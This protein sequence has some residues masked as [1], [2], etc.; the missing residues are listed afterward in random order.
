MFILHHDEETGIVAEQLD[1]PTEGAL[2]V[3]GQ[4]VGVKQHNRLEPHIAALDVGFRKE[5]EFFA[6]EFD[7]FAV[8]AIDKHDIGLDPRFLMIVDQ[9]DEIIDERTLARTVRPVKQEIGDAIVTMKSLQF[10]FNGIVHV[11][12][13]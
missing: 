5:F 11:A 12:W 10:S 13:W 4:A 7:A 3:N 1:A 6:N 2:R 8:R 9:V